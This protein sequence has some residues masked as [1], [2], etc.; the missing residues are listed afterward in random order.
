MDKE[1]IFL[2]KTEIDSFFKN[3]KEKYDKDSEHQRIK[4]L[5][6]FNKYI[7]RKDEQEAQKTAKRFL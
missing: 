2:S 7:K 6:W 3:Y 1:D 4:I 5:E